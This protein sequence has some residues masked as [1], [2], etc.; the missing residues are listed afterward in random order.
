MN[1]PMEKWLFLD[2][3]GSERDIMEIVV[4][5]ISP[6]IK[7]YLAGTMSE[8]KDI[9]SRNDISVIL[10]D[11]F[12]R[13]NVTAERFVA[14]ARSTHPDVPIIIVSSRTE[15]QS[16]VFRACADATIPKID[17]ISAYA[18]VVSAA[19]SKAKHLHSLNA[20]KTESVGVYI[21]PAI[22]AMFKRV[23]QRPSGNILVTSAPGMGRRA[24]ADAIA[25]N[26]KQRHPGR[27]SANTVVH[28]V[29]LRDCQSN[30]IHRILF[31]SDVASDFNPSGLLEQ[32]QDGILV[33]DDAH[34]LPSLVQKRLKGIWQDGVGKMDNGATIRSARAFLILTSSSAA[35]GEFEF[36]RGFLQTIIAHR[37]VLPKI[38]DLQPEYENILN[39]FVESSAKSR[40]LE[41]FLASPDFVS[42]AREMIVASPVR[43]TMRSIAKTV[44]SA[45]ELALIQKRNMLVAKDLDD[46]TFLYENPKNRAREPGAVAGAVQPCKNR[47]SA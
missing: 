43:V 30:A 23:S 2:D 36:E 40:Q 46:S 3:Q 1:P 35:A 27:F 41:D 47:N 39:F 6:N 18:K 7:L 34:L 25:Q 14:E 15:E 22:S 31:G 21:P 11:Y 19:V 17:D 24:I 42:R 33:L 8:A 5:D 12:L 13:N 32:C 29:T 4:G 28:R 20:T 26:L 10:S 9:L 37:M 44:D 16:A 38:T 45:V